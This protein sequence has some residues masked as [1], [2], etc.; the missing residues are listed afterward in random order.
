M[1]ALL[2]IGTKEEQHAVI[3]FLW[4]EGVSGAELHCRLSANME[5]ELYRS[6]VYEWISMYKNGCTSVTDEQ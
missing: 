6:K 2:S 5:T 3:R 1:A 4:A